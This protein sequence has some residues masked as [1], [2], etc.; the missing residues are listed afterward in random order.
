[1]QY[2]LLTTVLT[3][4]VPL[5]VSCTPEQINSAI[6]ACKGDPACYE[7]IDQAIVDELAS[8]G[9]T[10]G[11]MT[12]IELNAVTTFLSLYKNQPPPK[13]DNPIELS[14]SYAAH[15][16]RDYYFGTEQ[17]STNGWHINDFLNNYQ[18]DPWWDTFIDLASIN[19]QSKQLFYENKFSAKVLIY[20][21]SDNNFKYEIWTEKI[22]IFL[23][24]LN[25]N[26]LY[27]NNNLTTPLFTNSIT[28]TMINDY[29]DYK[30]HHDE[31]WV[32][33]NG[34]LWGWRKM[35]E[36]RYFQYNFEYYYVN[37]YNPYKAHRFRFFNLEQKE[38]YYLEIHYT[39]SKNPGESARSLGIYK[40]DNVNEFTDFG[41][42]VVLVEA[43]ILINQ[44]V[45]FS[46][47]A[48]LFSNFEVFSV[49]NFSVLSQTSISDFLNDLGEGFTFLD[50]EIDLSDEIII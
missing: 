6:E 35:S 16:G 5:V 27:F 38:S 25:I 11:K 50:L 48:T 12:N 37:G 3:I 4:I 49:D 24:D 33:S 28:E 29:I 30:N 44:K 22:D 14:S 9:I 47:F 23:I 26:R 10:G 15:F 41:K 40:F 7:I 36:D 20:K 45:S 31:D 46:D 42:R 34:D 2:K 1:M 39:G 43:P 13:I 32:D 21:T 18:P 8:R 17:F 19:T